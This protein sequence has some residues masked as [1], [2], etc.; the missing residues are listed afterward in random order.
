MFKSFELVERDENVLVS[1]QFETTYGTIIEDVD[2]KGHGLYFYPIYLFRRL[3]YPLIVIFLYEYPL[4]Q[5]IL[6]IAIIIL[7]V[8]STITLRCSSTSLCSSLSP[9]IP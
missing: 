1:Y 4:T 6:V 2:V 3:I 9:P 7:P 5:I 8:P